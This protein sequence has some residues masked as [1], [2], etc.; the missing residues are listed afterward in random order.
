MRHQGVSR[1][2]RSTRAG[3]RRH[4]C[5]P[6]LGRS[7]PRRTCAGPWQF[8][9]HPGSRRAAGE[10]SSPGTSSA[11][12][13]TTLS[14]P[15]RT[16]GRRSGSTT[17]PRGGSCSPPPGTR[18]RSGT[19]GK[20]RPARC[21]CRSPAGPFSAPS[22]RATPTSSTSSRCAVRRP[23]RLRRRPGQQDGRPHLRP[24]GSRQCDADLPGR[25]ADHLRQLT[26]RP[27]TSSP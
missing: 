10:T 3:N 8:A 5:A 6:V 20:T 22:R 24:L 27:P 21:F 14:T 1:M 4:R 16:A 23:H 15:S 12:P 9:G 7:S 25:G 17:M 11:I 19:C 18:S 2:T 13:P 26:T